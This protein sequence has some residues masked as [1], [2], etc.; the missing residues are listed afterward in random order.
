VSPETT[1]K[2]RALHDGGV[3]E[4]GSQMLYR[5]FVSE[6]SMNMF[7]DEL[8]DVKSQ[9]SFLSPSKDTTK[10]WTATRMMTGTS[11]LSTHPRTSW[12]TLPRRIAG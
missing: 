4:A 1:S 3:L 9:S 7:E 2:G 5:R 11:H 12:W 8:T 6:V 10:A